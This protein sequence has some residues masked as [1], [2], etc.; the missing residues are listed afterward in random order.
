MIRQY[1]KLYLF[2]NDHLSFLF[3]EAIIIRQLCWPGLVSFLFLE[4][5]HVFPHILLLSVF[6]SSSLDDQTWWSLRTWATNAFSF[7]FPS[8]SCALLRLY[9]LSFTT[10][11]W[12]SLTKWF[13]LWHLWHMR[14]MSF[15]SLVTIK[16]SEGLSLCGTL[17]DLESIKG[18]GWDCSWYGGSLG[19]LDCWS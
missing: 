14:T 18:M 4:T 17:V 1:H 15:F 2:N 12:Q 19:Y 7:S 11:V 3:Y 8:T 9:A 13:S 16:V 5:R 10:L 6:L